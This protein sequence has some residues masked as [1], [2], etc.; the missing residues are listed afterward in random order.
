[1]TKMHRRTFLA[2]AGMT[3]LA[4]GRAVSAP[5]KSSS[6]PLQ[7]TGNGEW[8]CVTGVFEG[9]FSMSAPRAALEFWSTTPMAV[10]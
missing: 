1:M 3:A 9:T 6:V 7:L 5:S 10:C 2:A 4:H 8:T